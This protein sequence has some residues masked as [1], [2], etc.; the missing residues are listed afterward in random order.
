MVFPT[1]CDEVIF[2]VVDS[3]RTGDLSLGL[4]YYIER[5]RTHTVHVTGVWETVLTRRKNICNFLVCLLSREF[6]FWH[7]MTRFEF[8]IR[9]GY[10]WCND[11]TSLQIQC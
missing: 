6:R 2:A 9:S 4:V 10:P 11:N 7:F 3:R 1:R 8:F 5:Y